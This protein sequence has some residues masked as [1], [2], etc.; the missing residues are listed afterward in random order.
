M[1]QGHARVEPHRGLWPVVAAHNVL[2][3]AA[4]RIGNHEFDFGPVGAMRRRR[5]GRTTIPEA[6]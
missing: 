6:R 3:C 4:R 2:G 5:S 1:F